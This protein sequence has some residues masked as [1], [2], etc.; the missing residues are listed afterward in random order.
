LIEFKNLGVLL[1]LGALGDWLFLS[2]AVQS[3]SYFCSEKLSLC[4]IESLSLCVKNV[5][6]FSCLLAHLAIGSFCPLRFKVFLIS[7]CLCGRK[8][9]HFEQRNCTNCTAVASA[10]PFAANAPIQRRAP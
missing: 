2:S 5:L 8:I 1:S 3:F 10:E 9:L 7:L 4:A 6:A